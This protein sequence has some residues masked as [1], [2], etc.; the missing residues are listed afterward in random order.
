VLPLFDSQPS[1]TLTETVQNALADGAVVLAASA[2]AARALRL[3]Y[4]EQQRRSGREMW[5][6]PTLYD[7]EGWLNRLWTDFLFAA[8]EAPL[9][10][11][12]AQEHALWKRVQHDD[13][14]LV[15]S[16]DGLA[17]LAQSAYALI[18]SYELHDSRKA[19]WFETDA[20]RFRHWAE[21][22]DRLCRDRRWA[23]R[24]TLESRL[25]IAAQSQ[26]L[27]LPRRILLAGFDRFTPA[28]DRFFEALRNAG[29]QIEV[30]ELPP[31]EPDTRTLIYAEDLHDELL[32]CAQWCRIQLENNPER[33]I[34]VI[35]PDVS[36]IQATADRV[37]RVVLMPQ[38]LDLTDKTNLMPFEFS[39]GTPL[40]TVPVVKA[41]LLLM[42]WTTEAL[43]EEQITWLLLSGFFHESSAETLALAQFDFKQRDAGL[44]SPET[45]LPSCVQNLKR[46][47]YAA[48]TSLARRLQQVLQLVEE[49]MGQAQTKSFAYW[50]EV[51]EELLHLAGWPGYR[52]PDTIQFQAQNRWQH[53]LDEV[54]LLDFTGQAVSFPA[55]L[56][57]LE[58]QA[59]ETVFTPESHSAPIQIVG[60]FESSGQ[61]FD[62]IW[63]LGTDDSQWPASGRPHPLLPIS[64]QRQKHMPHSTALVDME[65][66]RIVTARIANSAPECVVS[67]AQ[68]NKEGELRPS[69]LLASIFRRDTRAISAATFR[70]QLD[71]KQTA[72][73]LPHLALISAEP[74]VPWPADRSAGGADVLKEQAACPFQAFSKRRLAARLLNRTEWGLNAAERGNILHGI[75][76]N[77][78]SPET[79]EPFHMVSLDDL[80]AVVTS[81][82]LD[83]VLEYHIRNAFRRF[84]RD[85]T[86]DSWTHAYFESEQ[87]RLLMLLREWMLCEAERQPF[88]VEAREQRLSD[89]HVGDLK[90]NLRADRIDLLADRSHLLIDYKT[91]EMSTAKWQG[92]RPDEPQLPLYAVY[93]NVEDVSGLLFAQIRAG[94]TGMIGRVA[95]AQQQLQAGLSASSALVNQ[96]YD[97]SM[98][99][100]WKQALRNLADEF[101]QGEA[102]VDPK[103]GAATC[104]YCPLPGLCRI[105]ETGQIADEDEM[106][107]G[108]G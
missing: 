89:V 23:S 58:R 25:S 77:I 49:K 97:A 92:D 74:T 20:E 39:L 36:K 1:P 57:A 81:R 88:T 90:L 50:C 40:S 22:F 102:S 48:S 80:R 54:A 37:F 53:L 21:S 35:T 17:S 11:T 95:N 70:K 13:A 44:L 99:D 94:K 24:S 52:S 75:L 4:S 55:F 51:A 8:P 62:A 78:W 61:T 91:S 27:A 101:L 14:Q 47:P 3:A 59:N 68:Q 100:G 34:G 41:A 72:E 15:V 56:R 83:E 67:Y 38:S 84:D 85:R 5:A 96:P 42:R 64:L 107:N 66:A 18:S 6:S 30:V 93:G 43:P 73:K 69:P 9:L 31:Q 86:Q 63:F 29:T 103:Q 45:P 46:N 12:P 105:A 19:T 7:M 28:Q 60:A 106:E 79:P 33:R 71:I 32:A 108:N 2:R 16:P 87:S 65:L 76:E 98:R 26:L 10:L 104:K 82:R